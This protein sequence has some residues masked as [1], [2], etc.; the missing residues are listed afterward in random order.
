M[1][2]MLGG[3][4]KTHNCPGVEYHTLPSGSDMNKN[5]YKVEPQEVAI[6]AGQNDCM[7]VISHHL[8]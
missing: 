8:D 4:N 6:F 3:A 7:L 2:G 1:Q 5:N